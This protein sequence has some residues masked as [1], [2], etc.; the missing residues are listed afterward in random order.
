MHTNTHANTHARTHARSPCPSPGQAGG[1]DI[2]GVKVD[3]GM[4]P[5][6]GLGPGRVI[7]FRAQCASEMP[8]KAVLRSA[9]NPFKCPMTLKVHIVR[10]TSRPPCGSTSAAWTHELIHRF[11]SCLKQPTNKQPALAIKLE[12]FQVSEYKPIANQPSE[13]YMC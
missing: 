9:A 12:P 1:R 11:L 6:T 7:R 5:R 10:L 8:G 2:R 4:A 13:E 3:M